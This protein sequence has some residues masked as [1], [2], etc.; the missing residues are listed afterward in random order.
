MTAALAERAAF[1]DL[2]LHCLTEACCR[3]NPDQ[4]RDKDPE[5]ETA[6]DLYRTWHRAWKEACR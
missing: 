1:D 6:R 5:C 4:P 2:A 3:R